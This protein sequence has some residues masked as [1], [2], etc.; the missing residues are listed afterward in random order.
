MYID[1][2]WTATL[3]K[4]VSLSCSQKYKLSMQK[5]LC[6]KGKK[7]PLIPPYPLKQI[8]IVLIMLAGE[9]KQTYALL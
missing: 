9:K 8:S 6:G 1:L 3:G 5:S 4:L 2:K 7:W